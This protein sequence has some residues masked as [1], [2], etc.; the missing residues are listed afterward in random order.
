MVVGFRDGSARKWRI[1]VS[2][3]NL[4]PIERAASPISTRQP[5]K[6]ANGRKRNILLSVQSIFGR[7]SVNDACALLETSIKNCFRFSFPQL[8]SNRWYQLSLAAF[9][10][11]FAALHPK[12]ERESALRLN[13]Q[14]LRTAIRDSIALQEQKMFDILSCGLTKEVSCSFSEAEK[15]EEMEDE[16]TD[17]FATAFKQTLE[18]TGRATRESGFGGVEDFD[19]WLAR[20]ASA[21][22][23][24]QLVCHVTF[25]FSMR[26]A[27]LVSRSICCSNVNRVFTIASCLV[28]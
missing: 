14:C 15:P 18:D 10:Q 5:K 1:H 3:L 4:K 26:I 16:S 9:D 28:E 12:G 19:L 11:V 24:P 6:S 7:D 22:S 8:E 21:D 27:F 20:L 25:V 2:T 23:L 17:G 13:I